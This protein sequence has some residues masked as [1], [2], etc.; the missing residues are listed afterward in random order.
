MKLEL[1][2]AVRY[3]TWVLRTQLRPFCKKSVHS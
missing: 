3:P 1:Q 2:V